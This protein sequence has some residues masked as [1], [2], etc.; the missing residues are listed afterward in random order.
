ML[1]FTRDDLV[2]IWEKSRDPKELSNHLRVVA[3]DL[4]Q[5]A[6]SGHIGSSFSVMD[7]AL[8]VHLFEQGDSFP[9]RPSE[10]YRLF[11]SKGH[12][13]PAIYSINYLLDLIPQSSMH[14]RRLGF[15]PGHPEIGSGGT[16][17]NTGSLGMGISKAKGLAAADYLRGKVTSNY[18]IL[19]D[20][21]LQ[22]G[23]IWES[24]ADTSK[25][26]G[27]VIA[28]VDG[29]GIQSDTWV[30]GTR[31]LGDVKRRVE[32]T[33]WLFLEMDGHS[34]D[35]IL[36]T[37]EQAKNA[38][39]PAFIWANTVKGFGSTPISTFPED[40]LFYHYHSGALSPD[41]AE[42][43]RDELLGSS[44]AHQTALAVD[45]SQSP[46]MKQPVMVNHWAEL[47]ETQMLSDSRIIAMDGD[48]ALDTGTYRVAATIPDRYMQM[49]IAEQDMVSTA[50]GLALGGFLPVVHGFSTFLTMRPYEQIVNNA[51]E[52]SAIVYV[53]FLAGI[54][55]SAAGFSHQA[56]NDLAI[57]CAVPN[58]LV[59]EPATEQE[60]S[61]AFDA[62]LRHQGPSYLRLNSVPLPKQKGQFLE[63][64]GS[65]ATAFTLGDS[66]Q[67]LCSGAF[68]LSNSLAAQQIL[69]SMGILGSVV[70]ISAKS[71]RPNNLDLIEFASTS[72]P[73]LLIENALWH[74]GVFS[75]IE[76]AL[77][78]AGRRPL[79]LVIPGFP[80]NG[81]PDEVARYHG[82]DPQ[83]IADL[84]S[85]SIEK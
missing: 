31:S 78:R 50:G 28:I 5:A 36:A 16:V 66:Y 75:E 82:F 54:V 18:V 71:P 10:S 42:V 72:S 74:Y 38:E 24:L 17:T 19:G 13:A 67:I 57:M 80:Q 32:A 33:G 34:F 11:S 43:V 29:N 63:L 37:L 47:L 8:A 65:P 20:G 21:E 25:V 55:P 52:G 14:L 84:I 9:S 7:V 76:S 12:D 58:M 60:L 46:K 6:G 73:V 49:G 59:F 68:S 26:H 1:S 3:L 23:Q 35:E 56:V 69:S 2:S 70:S 45:F 48:L 85:T 44:G 53:G 64:G 41:L 83:S 77:L 4:I 30:E 81:Q 15:L 27:K 22:E 62:C 39:E 40:G 79:R 61:A 51:S